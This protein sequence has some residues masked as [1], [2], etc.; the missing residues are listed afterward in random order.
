MNRP[1]VSP[2]EA[3]LAAMSAAEGAERVARYGFRSAG[4]KRSNSERD[5]HGRGSQMVMYRSPKS[6]ESWKL[7]PTAAAVVS[8]AVASAISKR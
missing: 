7:V 3:E 4:H 1:G 2:F 8:V 5:T 6:E